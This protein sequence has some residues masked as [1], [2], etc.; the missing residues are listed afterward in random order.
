MPVNPPT[1]AALM[2]VLIL[3]A[4]C[5]GVQQPAPRIIVQDT[6]TIVRLDTDTSI[7]GPDDPGRYAHP[8][9]IGV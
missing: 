6:Q 1:L 3:V 8:A 5:A 9:E 2:L 4:G 7:K